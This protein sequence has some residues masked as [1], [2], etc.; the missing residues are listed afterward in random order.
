MPL[1]HFNDIFNKVVHRIFT[2]SL[3]TI[4]L[5]CSDS[6]CLVNYSKVKH[7]DLFEKLWRK[8]PNK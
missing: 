1:A 3:L 6:M 4:C 7:R 5:N 8:E 2:L